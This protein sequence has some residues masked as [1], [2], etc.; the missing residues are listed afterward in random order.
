LLGLSID[1]WLKVIQIIATIFFGGA[2]ICVSVYQLKIA[3]VKQKLELYDRR[4]VILKLTKEYVSKVLN[5]PSYSSQDFADFKVSTAESRF[6]FGGDINQKVNK[7]VELG[8]EI[9][10]QNIYL[11]EMRSG[12]HPSSAPD[13]PARERAKLCKNLIKTYEDMNE[14]LRK[15]MSLDS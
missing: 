9:D 11:Q 14:I 5:D 13:S 6:L 2:A 15:Y 1:N 7:L 8:T 3:Q 12:F 4:L 10:L